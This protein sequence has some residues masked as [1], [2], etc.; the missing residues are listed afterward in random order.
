MGGG[1]HWEGGREVL[2]I[3]GAQVRTTVGEDLLDVGWGRG[4]G[5]VVIGREGGREVL[6]VV[7]AQVRSTAGEDQY[8]FKTEEVSLKPNCGG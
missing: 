7:G 5:E 2:P 4:R 8:V 6:P 1:P 3:V